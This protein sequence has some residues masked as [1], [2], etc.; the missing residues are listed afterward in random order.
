MAQTIRFAAATDA[1]QIL[2]I[3][4][5]IVHARDRETSLQQFRE[6]PF[7]R[8]QNLGQVIVQ[9]RGIKN[10]GTSLGRRVR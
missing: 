1:T 4:A 10:P 2:D 8:I 9:D 6:Q 5:P 7:V 3:D